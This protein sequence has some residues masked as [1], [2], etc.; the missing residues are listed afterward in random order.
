MI[1]FEKF[2][3]ESNALGGTSTGSSKALGTVTVVDNATIVQPATFGSG[4]TQTPEAFQ[5]TNVVQPVGKDVQ[6]A[7]NTPKEPATVKNDVVDGTLFTDISHIVQAT[8]NATP[9][10]PSVSC[11]NGQHCIVAGQ[12]ILGKFES[13]EQAHAELDINND[14]Y[15]DWASTALCS[16]KMK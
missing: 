12:T 15:K 11:I 7:S 13:P 9:H 4:P 5:G 3:N 14:H 6:N 2:L 10:E 8:E 1:D 16:Q